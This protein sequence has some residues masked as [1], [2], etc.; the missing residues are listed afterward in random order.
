MW[1][2]AVVM[3][4]F[5]LRS[6]S[7]QFELQ[8]MVQRGLTEHVILEGQKLPFAEEDNTSH[9]KPAHFIHRL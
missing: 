3:S 9:P 7:L 2:E 6:E 5:S 1:L 8:P 4:S